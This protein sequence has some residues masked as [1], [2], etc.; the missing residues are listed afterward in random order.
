MN[1]DFTAELWEYP[2]E[3]A[4]FFICLPKAYTAEIKE[5]AEEAKRGFGSV[6]VTVTIGSSTWQTSIFP[7]KQSGAYLLPVKKA[8]RQKQKLTAGSKASVSLHV[9]L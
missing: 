9:T 8:I 4:W 3:G 6:R 7:D 5:V 2:G 1:Y